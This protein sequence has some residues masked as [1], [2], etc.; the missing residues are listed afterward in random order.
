M[1]KSNVEITEEVPK[2]EGAKVEISGTEVKVSGKLGIVTREFSH[3]RIEVS[4]KGG[5]LCVTSRGP[6]KKEKALMGTWGSHLNNM[7]RGVTEGFTYK[8][9]IVYSHFPMKAMVKG[10]D[11]VIENFIGERHPRVTRILGDTKVQVKGDIVEITG[12][13]KEHVGQTAANIEQLTRI[14]DNDPRVFQDGIYITEKA[15]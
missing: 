9:K 11:F 1:T 4:M 8:M 10:N 5:N 12:P 2:V 6:S 15:K 7:Q 3:P 13:D 14:K